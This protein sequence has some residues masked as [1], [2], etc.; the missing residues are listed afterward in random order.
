MDVRSHEYL[1]FKINS[2]LQSTECTYLN[3]V[4]HILSS[5]DQ[6]MQLS[7]QKHSFPASHTKSQTSI[8]QA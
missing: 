5:R 2:Q 3:K 6:H 1:T 7:S 4:I 8:C